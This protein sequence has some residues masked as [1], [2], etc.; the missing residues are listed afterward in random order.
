MSDTYFSTCRNQP[1]PAREIALHV[2][3]VEHQA[4]IAGV[5]AFDNGST[6]LARALRAL[7]QKLRMLMAF[8]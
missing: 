1:R 5:L 4:A 7:P 2:R 3:A 6:R 8:L